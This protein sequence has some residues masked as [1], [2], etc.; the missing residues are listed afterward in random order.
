MGE[1]KETVMAFITGVVVEMV[2]I[3]ATFIRVWQQLDSVF[4]QSPWPGLE[5][6]E[7]I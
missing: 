4:T 1:E 2:K 5:K 3:M 6:S 7:K